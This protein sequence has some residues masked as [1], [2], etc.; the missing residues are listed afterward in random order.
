MDGFSR[1]HP[2]VNII[3]YIAV[4]GLTMFQ[5][6]MGMIVISFVCGA[7]YYFNL[8]GISGIKYFGVIMVVF[9]VSSFIN[10]IFSHRGATLLFYMFTGNP[11]TLESIIYG[12][13]AALLISSALLWFATFNQVISEDKILAV[14]G[15][16]MPHVALLVTMVARFVPKYINQQKKVRQARRDLGDRPNNLIG[17]IKQ[18]GEIF[19]ITMTWAL[20]TSVETADSMRAR[21]Y[22]V[23][24]RSN[25]NNYRFS[26]RDFVAVAW[27]LTL[28]VL[29]CVALLQGKANTYYYPYIRVKNSITVYLM[30]ALLC[31]TPVIINIKE[32]AVW[33]RLK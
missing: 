10:P 24:K 6:Q 31:L 33:H 9:A 3:F 1:Y 32:A 11:V 26:K 14:L 5:M 22:G 18:S 19:S 25:Y 12:I 4:L 28:F 30:Y 8:R 7:I 29:V 27:I 20:E 21:G 2:V 16:V 23:A 15:K 13:C 17:K